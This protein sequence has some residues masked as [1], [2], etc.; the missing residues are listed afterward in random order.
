M[1]CLICQA[2][3][4]T[5]HAAG[6]WSEVK[7]SAGCGR[8]K[9]SANL[10]AKMKLKNEFFDIERTRRWLEMARNDDPVPLI[11]TYDY[12]VSLLHRDTEER[13]VFAPSRSRQPLVAD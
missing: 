10:V 1:K 9:V 6:D 11:S 4:N 7:C 3:S 8:Y 13:S 2:A 5:V 12:F